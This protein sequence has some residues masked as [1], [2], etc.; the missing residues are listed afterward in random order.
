[1]T[2]FLGLGQADE[3]LN[4]RLGQESVDGNI[5]NEVPKNVLH[6]VIQDSPRKL[7]GGL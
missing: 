7:F 4:I 6:Q 2:L 5:G 1:L 3:M